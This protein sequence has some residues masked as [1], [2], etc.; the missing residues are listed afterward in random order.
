MPDTWERSRVRAVAVR[1]STGAV[2]ILEPV[3]RF[4]FEMGGFTALPPADDLAI[5]FPSLADLLGAE[6]SAR[7]CEVGIRTLGTLVD[8]VTAL[9]D[10]EEEL[11]CVLFLDTPSGLNVIPVERPRFGTT[12][13]LEDCPLERL[14]AE[15]ETSRLGAEELTLGDGVVGR[16][17]E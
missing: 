13:T 9:S 8:L 15:L 6:E 2:S 3:E 1:F 16:V 11:L 17:R 5:G 4:R 12:D 10:R 14:V 7:D